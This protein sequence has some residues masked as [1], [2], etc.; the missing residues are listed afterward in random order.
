MKNIVV[1]YVMPDTAD[2]DTRYIP[3]ISNDE[4]K[5]I[6]DYKY[7]SLKSFEEAFNNN[8]AISD[9]GYIRFIEE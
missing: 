5:K 2:T 3:N 8:N 1:Y 6:A 9:L 4:F 7:N